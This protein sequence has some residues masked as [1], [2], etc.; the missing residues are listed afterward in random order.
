[1]SLVKFSDYIQTVA[2]DLSIKVCPRAFVQFFSE[3][4]AISA[5]GEPVGEL[6]EQ[7]DANRANGRPA[8]TRANHFGQVEVWLDDGSYWM[9]SR[10]CQDWAVKVIHVIAA[11][12]SQDNCAHVAH[13]YS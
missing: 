3:E 9:A 2:E 8:T 10:C 12:Q 6:A 4:P 13:V 1:M 5:L 11:E 7:Y